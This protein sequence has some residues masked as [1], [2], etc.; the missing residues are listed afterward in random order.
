MNPEK[1]RKVLAPLKPKQDKG[2]PRTKSDLLIHYYQWIHVEK[3][4]RIFLD[5]E[6]QNLNSVNL[7]YCSD[8]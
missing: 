1:L 3:R 5:G 4:E 8:E 2:M 7:T 6:E